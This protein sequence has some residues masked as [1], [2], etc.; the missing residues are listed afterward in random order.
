MWLHK[1]YIQVNKHK[2]EGSSCWIYNKKLKTQILLPISKKYIFY[3]S[4]KSKG[5]EE[6][7]TKSEENI[8]IIQP[9]V[10][11]AMQMKRMNSFFFPL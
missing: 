7:K 2:L 5:H 1:H 4:Q 9:T 11:E 6:T 10:F 3:F 8:K